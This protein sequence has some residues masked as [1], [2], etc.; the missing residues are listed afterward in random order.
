MTDYAAI[1]T[2]VPML[3]AAARY[4]ITPVRGRHALCPFHSEKTPSLVL[5][6]DGFYCFGCGA[7]GDVI[8]FVARLFSLSPHEAADRLD[9]DFCLELGT[10]PYNAAAALRR[11]AAAR[12]VAEEVERRRSALNMLFAECRCLRRCRFDRTGHNGAAL[13]YY[14]YATQHIDELTTEEVIALV[15][16]FPC[17]LG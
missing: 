3:E 11:E 13:G 6:P 1:R 16:G 2:R 15:R 5:Y 10:A 8:D 14:D 12:R 9:A 17:P 4:G 7:G